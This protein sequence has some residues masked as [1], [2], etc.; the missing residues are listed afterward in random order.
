MTTE[1]VTLKH[2]CREFELDAYPLRQKLRKK[3]PH[4]PNQ[5]WKWQPDDPQLKEVRA[6]AKTMKDQLNA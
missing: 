3:L 5:R 2:I 1:I 6:I 4:K